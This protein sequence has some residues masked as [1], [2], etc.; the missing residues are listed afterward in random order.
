MH[1]PTAIITD[2]ANQRPNTTCV[3]LPIDFIFRG[4][5]NSPKYDVNPKPNIRGIGPL[6]G[7]ISGNGRSVMHILAVILSKTCH[8]FIYMYQYI[9]MRATLSGKEICPLL[10]HPSIF[11][12]F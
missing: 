1:N 12:I 10:M 2:S 7:R 8:F 4:I 5:F 9:F 11:L 6:V 3:S